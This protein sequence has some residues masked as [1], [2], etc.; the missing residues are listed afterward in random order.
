M[1]D[2][3]PLGLERLFRLAD[4]LVSF[5][6]DDV[7]VGRLVVGDDRRELPPSDRPDIC[8]PSVFGS[9]PVSQDVLAVAFGPLRPPGIALSRDGPASNWVVVG[10]PVRDLESR[11]ER[12]EDTLVVAVAFD[13]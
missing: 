4:L 11:I 9:I 13:R 5:R 2:G 10:S 3:D 8:D 12:V 7:L 1:L 6:L